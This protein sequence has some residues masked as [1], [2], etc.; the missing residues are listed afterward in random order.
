M[1]D[2]SNTGPVPDDL[3]TRTVFEKVRVPIMQMVEAADVSGLSIRGRRFID[4]VISGPAV[5]IPMNDT[6][7]DSCNMGET[8]G[9]VRNLFLR[10]A[11]PKI[12]GAIPLPGCVFE[13][14]VFVGIGFAGDDGF[15]DR[16]AST[17]SRTK[18]LP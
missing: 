10:A 7:F 12:V 11:G 15:V 1:Y 18:A 5:V 16:L 13:G 17:L 6:V 4:C 8:A 14:C 2:L 3:G 9:D